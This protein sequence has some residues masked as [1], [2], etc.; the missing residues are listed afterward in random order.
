MSP[1]SIKCKM[2]C[3]RVRKKIFFILDYPLRKGGQRNL[4]TMFQIHVS[5]W[6]SYAVSK[7]ER[8]FKGSFPILSV[9]FLCKQEAPQGSLQRISGPHNKSNYFNQDSDC[10]TRKAL[11]TE[12][13]ECS[14]SKTQLLHT[15]T[16][17][18]L[19]TQKKSLLEIHLLVQ[20]ALWL[21]QTWT[22]TRLMTCRKSVMISGAWP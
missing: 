11:R 3:S 8:K 20:D 5:A 14:Q 12:F 2:L 15:W 19:A 18:S 13:W 10:K 6:G 21:H 4:C 17:H 7:V 16:N 9:L 22:A 1:I